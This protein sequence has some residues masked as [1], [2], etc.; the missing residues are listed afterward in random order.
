MSTFFLGVA[1]GVSICSIVYLVFV[2]VDRNRN[3]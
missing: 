1:V 2:V 3:W